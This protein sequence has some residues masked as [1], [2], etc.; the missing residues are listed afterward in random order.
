MEA[1]HVELPDEAI[2]LAVPEIAR[3]HY[4]LESIGILYYEL[5]S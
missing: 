3:Q 2:H 1:I 4:L 5:G